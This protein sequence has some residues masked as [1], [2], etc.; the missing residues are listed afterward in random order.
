MHKSYKKINKNRIFSVITRKLELKRL[1]FFY[2]KQ[3]DQCLRYYYRIKDKKIIMIYKA[4][5]KQFKPKTRK[6]A[7]KLLGEKVVINNI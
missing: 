1:I 2:I 7:D 4:R 3:S 5:M 6:I